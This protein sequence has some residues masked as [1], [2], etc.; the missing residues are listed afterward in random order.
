MK[1]LQQHIT[2][3]LIINKNY[4]SDTTVCKP[5]NNGTCLLIFIYTS[6]NENDYNIYLTLRKYVYDGTKID[7]AY[8]ET[9]DYKMNALGYLWC[10]VDNY[11]TKGINVLMFDDEA[12]NFLKG[13]INDPTEKINLSYT[14]DDEINSEINWPCNAITLTATGKHP[15]DKNKLEQLYKQII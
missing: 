6:Y 1:S 7:F 4:K 2:E 13:L 5:N 3:K 9:E 10:K 8:Y 15:Y 12:K 14:L 11:P